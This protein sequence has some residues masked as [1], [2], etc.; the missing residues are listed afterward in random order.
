M[1]AAR[2]SIHSSECGEG[3]GRERAGVVDCLARLLVRTDIA[4][5]V[6]RSDAF[7]TDAVIATWYKDWAATLVNRVN[8]FNGASPTSR[9][10]DPSRAS[11]PAHTVP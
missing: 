6:F 10:C 3:Y 8:T 4:M 5:S 2:T 11:R 7:Y 9:G 1:L